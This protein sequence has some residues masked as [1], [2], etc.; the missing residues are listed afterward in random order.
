MPVVTV[1]AAPHDRVD[2]LLAAVADGITHALALG[3][4]D[5]IVT[6]VPSGPSI[7]SGA[8]GAASVSRWPLVTI[9]G[10]DRGTAR[11]K[12]ARASAEAAVRAWSRMNG[13][14]C[15]GVWTQWL[16]PLPE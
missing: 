13:V 5:V 15:E 3:P 2:R 4:G 10:S 8:A 7:M 12:A 9:H 16:T 1:V 14:E 6:L 11:M